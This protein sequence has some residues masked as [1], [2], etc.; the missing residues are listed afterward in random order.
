MLI[1]GYLYGIRSERRICEEVH[2][3]L[4]Y[5]WFCRLG[6]EDDVPERSVFSKTRHGRFRE[7]EAF[8]KVFEHVVGACMKAGLV[9]G[10]AFA[11]DA[12]TIEA[13]ASIDR[14]SEGAEAP[15]EWSKPE[16]VTRP[17]KEYLTILDQDAGFPVMETAEPQPAKAI[18]LT[19][20]VASLRHRP[21][22][23]A[24]FGYSDN[25]L[26]DRKHAIIVD[27]EA[28]PARMSTEVASTVTMIERTEKQFDLK[29]K[30]IAGDTAYGTGSLLHYLWERGIEPHVPVFDHKG[31]SDQFARDDFTYD[32]ERDEY[33]CPNGK[34]LHRSNKAPRRGQWIYFALRKDCSCCPLKTRCTT[35]ERRKLGISIYEVD[36]ERT[37]KLSNTQ[38]YQNSRRERK[39]VEMVF[40]HLKRTLNF[41]RLRL[42]GITG[43]RDEFLLVAIAQNLKKLVRHMTTAPPI[44]N[45]GGLVTV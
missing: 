31:H 23:S 36:R 29:P 32:Q 35:Y 20:P 25:V 37:R 21:K 14:R 19:D 45:A 39:K 8:R 17:I 7:S 30:N 22:G 1:I 43:A 24:C 12:S 13:D 18:S 9:G 10:E 42:R 34:A 44:I 26:I 15:K 27:V 28:T 5:R 3:N 40:A 38:A 16:A 4:A 11:I 41:R 2:Y 33:I 6:L